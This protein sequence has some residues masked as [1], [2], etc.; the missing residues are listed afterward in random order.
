MWRA[1]WLLVALSLAVLA[2]GGRA[3]LSARAASYVFLHVIESNTQALLH[4]PTAAYP[5]PVT[6]D[7]ALGAVRIDGTRPRP[8]SILAYYEID[9]LGVC[10]HASL[11]R[12]R[13]G[14]GLL[15]SAPR[16]WAGGLGGAEV[17][18]DEGRLLRHDL[19]VRAVAPDGSLEL[20]WAGQRRR[21]GPGEAWSLAVLA[22][23]ADPVAAG[24]G[25]AWDEQARAVL[26]AG[27]AASR[28]TVV[29]HGR[30]A[31]SRVT[32]GDRW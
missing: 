2:W 21:L 19:W 28:V 11:H 24:P 22:P 4:L 32:G 20:E 18:A 23:G 9:A 3:L 1:R 6:F 25:P 10:V 26:A 12:L 8:A 27:G 13:P 14:T 30:W 15:L 7:P 16:S 29:N 31:W 5:S 17:I